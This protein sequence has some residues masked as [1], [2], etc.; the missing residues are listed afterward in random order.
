M[1]YLSRPQAI[2]S[3]V[4]EDEGIAEGYKDEG[5]KHDAVL[6]MA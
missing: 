3:A 6:R 1:M 2:S 4:D 5:Q